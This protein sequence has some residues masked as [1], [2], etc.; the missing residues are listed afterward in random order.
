MRIDVISVK[1]EFS[2]CF[3]NSSKNIELQLFM[4]STSFLSATVSKTRFT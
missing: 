1:K 4:S 2:E 3:H